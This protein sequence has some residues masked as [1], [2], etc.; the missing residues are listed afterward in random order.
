LNSKEIIKQLYQI[1]D[2]QE[3]D[4]E[5]IISNPFE[6]MIH[7]NDEGILVKLDAVSMAIYLREYDLAKKLCEKGVAVSYM[8]E[9]EIIKNEADGYSRA[10]KLTLGNIIIIRAHEMSKELLESIHLSVN[11]NSV[12]G[13][14][15]LSFADDYRLNPLF[16]SDYDI[17]AAK[18]IY[19]IYKNLPHMLKGFMKNTDYGIIEYPLVYDGNRECEKEYLILKKVLF[20]SLKDSEE[21]FGELPLLF[22]TPIYNKDYFNFTGNEGREK[23]VEASE[24]YMEQLIEDYDLFK[25]SEYLKISYIA[26]AIASIANL[27]G[28]YRDD[29]NDIELRKRA[30]NAVDWIVKLMQKEYIGN[31]EITANMLAVMKRLTNGISINNGFSESA[32]LGPSIVNQ[33]WIYNYIFN[34]DIVFNFCKKSDYA[35]INPVI[36]CDDSTLIKFLECLH[37]VSFDSK[38]YEKNKEMIDE[39][40]LYVAGNIL[41]RNKEEILQMALAKG[42]I[43]LE[44][45]EGVIAAYKSD[46]KPNDRIKLMPVLIAYRAAKKRA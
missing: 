26:G 38:E 31:E 34:F 29:N 2:R 35:V 13:E 20:Q 5:D 45:L 16:N 9:G 14:L 18:S 33:M 42:L 3:A 11:R 30:Y 27:I 43:P 6:V 32:Q 1:L 22:R 44:V 15:G 19:H 36:E 25:N 7:K 24:K 10:E 21:D 8:N 28:F 17:S 41:K 12:K 46:T 40:I 4:D 23:F 39:N 37:H